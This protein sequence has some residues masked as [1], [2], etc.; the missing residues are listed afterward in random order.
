MLSLLCRPVE[1]ISQ[2]VSV[3]DDCNVSNLKLYLFYLNSAFYPYD[4]LNLDFG[5]KTSAVLFDMYSRFVEHI[6]VLSVSK[7]Y[8]M[9]SHLPRKDLL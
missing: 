3:F 4:D 9:C 5:K 7:H 1:R 2:D 6:M 8:L